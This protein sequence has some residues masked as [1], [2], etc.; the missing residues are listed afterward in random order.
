MEDGEVAIHRYADEYV[1]AQIQTEGS[2][3][4][5]YLTGE[6]SRQPLDGY[7]PTDLKKKQMKYWVLRDNVAGIHRLRKVRACSIGGGVYIV[8]S[9]RNDDVALFD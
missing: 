1:A 2:E 3:K 7:S 5:K 8:Q 6:I 4:E 9:A